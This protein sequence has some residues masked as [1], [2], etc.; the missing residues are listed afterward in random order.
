MQHLSSTSAVQTRFAVCGHLRFHA[1]V[2]PLHFIEWF[3]LYFLRAL[4]DQCTKRCRNF[5]C[6]FCLLAVLS[7]HGPFIRNG[8]AGFADTCTYLKLASV[9]V[10]DSQFSPTEK[11]IFLPFL[12]SGIFT[13]VHRNRPMHALHT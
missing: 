13:I 7:T 6:A 5:R 3:Q 10:G 4:R 8:I 11:Q 12:I 9:V 1:F 2:K